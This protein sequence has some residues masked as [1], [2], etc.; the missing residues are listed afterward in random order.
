[1]Q[2]RKEKDALA[3]GRY[4]EMEQNMLSLIT[5]SMHVSRGKLIAGANPLTSET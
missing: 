1:M 4:I 2:G 3:H 5:N